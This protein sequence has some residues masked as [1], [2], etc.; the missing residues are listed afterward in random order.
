MQDNSFTLTLPG[1]ESQHLTIGWLLLALASLVFAGLFTIL[2]VLSRTP[3]FQEIIPWL[4]F[5]HTALVVHVD[6]TVLVWF[7]SFAGVLWSFNS[8]NRCLLCGKIA[9]FF[10]ATG[11]LII[12]ISP[13][14]GEGNP[15]MNNY[16]PVLQNNVFFIGLC[17]FGLGFILLILRSFIAA[18]PTGDIISKEGALR[19]ALYTALLTALIAVL[20]LGLSYLGINNEPGGEPYYDR[21]FWGS[22]H[23][24]Q[25]THTL[26]MLTVWLWLATVS[27]ATPALPPRIVMLLFAIGMSPALGAAYI[28]ANYDV[29]SNEHL[30]SFFSLMKYGGGLAA[31]PVGIAVLFGLIKNW[32]KVTPGAAIERNALIYSMLLFGTGGIIGYLIIG[33]NVTIPA[34]YHGS[35]VG[36]TLAYMG[37]TYHLLPKLGFRKVEG[38]LAQWQPAIYGIGQLM[39]IIGL[40]WSGGYGVQRKTAGAEQGLKQFEQ[41]AGMGLMGLGGL[42]SII[43]GVIFLVVVY[44]AIKS[45]KK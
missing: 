13:F 11:T 35:I 32:K 36:V 25:F 27:G 3:F 10:A 18:R 39:H 2:I 5:F 4:D 42:I 34:H 14:T 29:N 16:V 43:G 12:T 19:F 33:S 20:A 21:L 24:L 6:L 37:I 41:V 45:E 1:T 15:L 17:I 30:V 26:L 7:L 23:I 28:Y 38:R 9:L 8:N 31:L 40:A 22:G 44:L